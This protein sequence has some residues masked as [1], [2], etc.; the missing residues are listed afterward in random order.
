[1]L[2]M[3]TFTINIPPMLA[4]IPY[5][6]PM[7]YVLIIWRLDWNDVQDLWIQHHISFLK[8]QIL[9]KLEGPP[10][11]EF[12]QGPKHGT[13]QW[14]WFWGSPTIIVW[15]TVLNWLLLDNMNLLVILSL[16][17]FTT[18]MII[19]LPSANLAWQGGIPIFRRRT[20]CKYFWRVH[21]QVLHSPF[22]WSLRL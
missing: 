15:H 2:Y 17:L 7:G 18:S 20:I 16:L 19:A 14:Y 10:D 13:K 9:A 5:M 12:T 6:D 21:A 4:Y 11:L 8:R 1:M 22:R 3:V